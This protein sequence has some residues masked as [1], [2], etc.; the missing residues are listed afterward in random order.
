MIDL[1]LETI[2]ENIAERFFLKYCLDCPMV[3]KHAMTVIDPP[4]INCPCDLDFTDSGCF[5]YHRWMRIE[6]LVNDL[7]SEVEYTLI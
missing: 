5:Q 3:E 4:E 2:K 6:D 7:D 1:I